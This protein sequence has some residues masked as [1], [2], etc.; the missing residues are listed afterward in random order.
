MQHIAAVHAALPPCTLLVVYS[1]TGD[2]RALV[3]MQEVQRVFR[4]EY[5]VK[6]WDELSVRWGDGEEE[7]LRRACRGA[8]VGVGFVCVK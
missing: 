2:P 3:R 6:K 7:G 4:R 1:G 8:R 5:K